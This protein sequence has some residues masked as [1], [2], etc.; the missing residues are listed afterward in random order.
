MP[1]LASFYSAGPLEMFQ[2]KAIFSTSKN[3][4]ADKPSDIGILVYVD[5]SKLTVSST[6][7]ATNNISL[8]KVYKAVDQ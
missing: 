8:A 2:D 5:D 7:I 1:I 4:K 6:S 3:L